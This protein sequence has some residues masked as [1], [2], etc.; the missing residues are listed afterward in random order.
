MPGF[1]GVNGLSTRSTYNLDIDPVCFT[2]DTD[3][4]LPVMV[5][6]HE[7]SG[8][9]F[10]INTIALNSSY[11]ND[12]YLDYD[13]YPLGSFHNFNDR[14]AVQPFFAR[15]KDR[16]CA[17]V[18]KN[19]FAAQFFLDDD[20]QFLLNGLC[21]TIYIVRNPVDLMLSYR[22]LIDFFP[23]DEGPK[24]RDI[25]EFLGC[26]PEGRML[27]YQNGQIATIIERWKAHIAAWLDVAAKNP[28]NV[29]VV[30]YQDLDLD[31]ATE[32]KRILSFLGCGHPD[33]IARPDRITHAIFVPSAPV[34]LEERERLR[35]AIVERLGRAEDIEHLFPAL[36]RQGLRML[37]STGA[38]QT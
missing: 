11:S 1:S 12:P 26:A 28:T 16:R 17:S 15:L 4:S 20:R 9:H 3:I 22:R 13:I 7:R 38:H 32:T 35:R 2:T 31:H 37:A 33:V 25:I 30:N 6:S 5:S 36:Y 29:M 18:I 27:R 21:K 8:T 34:S 14:K 24:R 23:W 10:L 19:H